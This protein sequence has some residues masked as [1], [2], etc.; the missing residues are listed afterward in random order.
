MTQNEKIAKYESKKL[1]I[2]KMAKNDSISRIFFGWF[3]MKK[4]PLRIG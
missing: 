3:A 2:F 1:E 4:K